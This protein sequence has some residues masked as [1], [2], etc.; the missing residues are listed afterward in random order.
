M[1]IYASVVEGAVLPPAGSCLDEQG[2]VEVVEL[3]AK[4]AFPPLHPSPRTP[5]L[6][7]ILHSRLPASCQDIRLTDSLICVAG[8]QTVTL[9]TLRAKPPPRVGSNKLLRKA[10]GTSLAGT[11]HEVQTAGKKLKK[12]QALR[13]TGVGL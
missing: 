6:C 13:Q 2:Q 7:G 5:L 11:I 10:D 3:I 12:Q 8:L 4:V 9:S 1:P